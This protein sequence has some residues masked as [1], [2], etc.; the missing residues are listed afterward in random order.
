MKR[1]TTPG[2]TP[3]LKI[4]KIETRETRRESIGA[5]IEKQADVLP[6]RAPI[7]LEPLKEHEACLEHLQKQGEA[8]EVNQENEYL[9]VVVL[10][11]SK[12]KESSEGDF[13]EYRMNSTKQN[14]FDGVQSPNKSGTAQTEE[15]KAKIF[16][17]QSS[18]KICEN[19]PNESSQVL[20][21]QKDSSFGQ[22]SH[23]LIENNQSSILRDTNHQL[24]MSSQQASLIT[25]NL[26]KDT[27]Q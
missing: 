12:T 11:A 10:E 7:T 18:I 1:A 4:K 21:S 5:I 15:S 22:P 8:A 17:D 23:P 26:T 2:T 14:F 24:N 27:S 6:E 9:Q 16:N 25:L 19:P 20:V 3:E 13:D